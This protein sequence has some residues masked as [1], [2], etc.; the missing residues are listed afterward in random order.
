MRSRHTS[1]FFLEG[2][3]QGEENFIETVFYVQKTTFQGTSS[4]VMNVL[5]LLNVVRFCNTKQ[6]EVFNSTSLVHQLTV[7]V[8]SMT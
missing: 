4:I 5:L 7:C 6:V 2:K 3:R 8:K 1:Q